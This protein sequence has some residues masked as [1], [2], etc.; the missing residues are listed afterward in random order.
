[1]EQILI[2]GQSAFAEKGTLLSDVLQ[3]TG[4][5][6]MP[7]GGQ[8]HCGKCKVYAVGA[9]SEPDSVERRFLTEQE[10]KDAPP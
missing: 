7:C 9:L 10:L 2:N 3:E 5:Y 1:M 6:K 4:G 8:G